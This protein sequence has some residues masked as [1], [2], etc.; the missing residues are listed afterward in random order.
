MIS[1]RPK[2]VRVASAYPL[3][4][5]VACPLF[6]LTGCGNSR[7]PVP[8]LSQPSTPT[9]HRVLGYPSAG[10]AFE[11]P[12]NWAAVSDR[13]P[14]VSVV[15]SG[16]AVVAI[17]RY[18]RHKPSP[19]GSVA[20]NR[21]RGELIDAARARDAGLQVIHSKLVRLDHRSAIELDA[22]ERIGGQTRRVRSIH[23]FVRSAEIVLD[24]YA[25]IGL[26][27][28]VDHAVFSPLKR[29]LRLLPAA[30]A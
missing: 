3:L 6:L 22:I 20:L 10:L 24:E 9:G 28:G 29:S 11:A 1:A 30:T 26:F 19:V 23:V 25:P 2:R 13:G 5:L 21:A 18:P 16:S 4:L 14:L 7:A 12:S 15:S 17:W 27:H 8:S